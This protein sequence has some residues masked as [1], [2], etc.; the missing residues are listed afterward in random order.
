[1]AEEMRKQREDCEKCK[2][3]VH[4]KVRR[5]FSEKRTTRDMLQSLIRAHRNP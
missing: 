4:V 2:A 1:M 5:C 3:R